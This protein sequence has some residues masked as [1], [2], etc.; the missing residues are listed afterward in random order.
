MKHGKGKLQFKDGSC[1]EGDFVAGLPNGFGIYIAYSRE[2]IMS[3]M[4][5][6]DVKS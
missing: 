4:P 2:R 5:I 3:F 6:L 1:Y